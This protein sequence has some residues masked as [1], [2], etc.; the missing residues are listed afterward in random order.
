MAQLKIEGE[1]F[2]TA[3]V[4]FDPVDRRPGTLTSG[5][6]FVGLPD[7]LEKSLIAEEDRL[8]DVKVA[9]AQA[10][11]QNLTRDFQ[12]LL[13][14]DHALSLSYVVGRDIVVP[15]AQG[16]YSRIKLATSEV[17]KDPP[18][19]DI[20][21]VLALCEIVTGKNGYMF[22]ERADEVAYHGGKRQLHALVA[23]NFPRNI[24]QPVKPEDITVER[25]L[26]AQQETEHKIMPRE[27]TFPRMLLGI[28]LDKTLGYKPD[29]AFAAVTN[30]IDKQELSKRF[31]VDV[32]E[33]KGIREFPATERNLINVILEY[34]AATRHVPPGF[35]AAII[36]LARRYRLDALDRLNVEGRAHGAPQI[37]Y[38]II[39]R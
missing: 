18:R 15:V 2:V 5:V 10:R 37:E 13:R 7:T 3:L 19:K 21:N 34:S 20:P 9:D 32:W 35:A 36:E 39:G 11:G 28:I 4:P 16:T 29:I 8:W 27:I 38:N 24:I 26:E 1:T 12:Y 33:Q 23:G 14:P 30:M 17:E 25:W 6:K 31:A 22:V